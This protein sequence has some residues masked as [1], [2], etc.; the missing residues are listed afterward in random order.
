MR[1]STLLGLAIA[2]FLGVAAVVGIR[3]S[4]IL[5]RTTPPEKVEPPFLVLVAKQNMFPDIMATTQ[6]VGV[7]PA[8]A[9]E[10][11]E[12]RSRNLTDKLMPPY[13]AAANLRIAARSIGVDEILF[14][15][16]FQE[17][18]IP[19]GLSA[20]VDKGMRVVNLVL[21]PDRAS[22]GLLRVGEYVDVLL[23]TSIC[24]DPKCTVSRTATAP[25]AQNLKVVLK[26]NIFFTVLQGVPEN[27]PV[28]F[29]L[30][31]SPYKA[32]LIEFAKTKGLL[33]LIPSA[34]GG[35]VKLSPAQAKVEE[36][37]SAAFLSGEATINDQDLER[38]FNLRPLQAPEPPLMV[39]HYNGLKYSGTSTF[40][41]NGAPV[42]APVAYSFF[43]PP[44]AS[45]V[46]G[47][48]AFSAQTPPP[49]EGECPT[50]GKH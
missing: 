4:G 18:A 10:I 9:A 43:N 1:A 29:H 22:G 25:L 47:S 14:K 27:K 44:G 34:A 39:E 21:P 16:H 38:I 37:R 8:T 24:A 28:S 19:E 2:L 23:T 41:R 6:D 17:Q 31:A 50:C 12:L 5:D 26:R 35:P 45:G 11:V 46:Q 13:P 32:G 42:I 15:D 40:H 33:S 3:M 20:R 7:R 30:Q 36:A 49:P 48:T